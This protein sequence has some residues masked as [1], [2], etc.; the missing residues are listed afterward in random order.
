MEFKGS[1]T[2]ANLW[3][4][5]AA[6]AK[7][8][9]RYELYGSQARKDGY[10]QIAA[11]FCETADNE[12]AHAKLWLR[13]LQ[14]LG[15]TQQNLDTAAADEHKEWS[16]M[17]ADMA[18]I[19]RSEGFDA[20]ADQMDGVAQIEK[21]HEARFLQLLENLKDGQVFRRGNQVLWYCRNCGHVEL[22]EEAPGVC[23]VCG[24]PQSFF[25]INAQN[26]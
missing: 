14:E 17:Y 1:K 12:K 4:A 9:T 18:E 21:C 19:A 11:I 3:D 7:A 10:E 20:L 13:A 15:D 23:P 22:S 25:Q 8:R 6:E 5:F 2:E 24:H 16:Q 26:Y